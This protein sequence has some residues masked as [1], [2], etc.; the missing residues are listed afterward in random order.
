[1]QTLMSNAPTIR[2]QD[3]ML[4]LEGA[5][6]LTHHQSLQTLLDSHIV[7]EKNLT[8]DGSGL[9][10]LDTA[11]ALLL[12]YYV[13]RCGLS[14][15]QVALQGFSESYQ[16][17]LKTI[18]SRPAPDSK[19]ESYRMTW[20]GKFMAFIGRIT[21]LTIEEGG[22]I[23]SFTGHIFIAI[24]GLLRKPSEFRMG[25]W[26]RHMDEAGV[27]AIPIVSLLAFLISIVLA[28]QGATQLKTFGA[29]IFTIDLT[30]IS[31]LREMGVLLT[32]IMVAGRSGSAFAAEIGVM[33]LREEVD[34]MK[35]IGLNP[36]SLLV[37]PRVLALVVMMP[38][39]TFIAD[40]CGLVGTYLMTYLLL[41]VSMLQFIERCA[42]TVELNTFMVGI[43]KAPV[44][45]FLIALVGTY[46]GMQVSGSAESVGR[47]TTVAV[48]QSIFL[49]IFA[50]AL[51][52]ILFSTFGL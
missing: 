46:Q 26:V 29:D 25:A 17:F 43:V 13:E 50:D 4:Y 20:V 14:P 23:L 48:V 52:S 33:K 24:A 35:T 49:V 7:T 3:N 5:W 6:E 8:I 36:F 16:T 37:L 44:F 32:A 11:G 51:F 9:E 39:L 28:Y 42:D 40:I 41:D 47:L 21:S 27:R 22:N 30:A 15:A 10:A 31:I 19:A 12:K 34:A 2:L 38:I 18:W 45:G 1:M